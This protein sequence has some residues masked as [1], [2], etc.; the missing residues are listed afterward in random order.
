MVPFVGLVPLLAL[1]YASAADV[2][3]ISNGVASAAFSTTDGSLVSFIGADGVDRVVSTSKSVWQLEV[4]VPE[5]RG[6]VKIAAHSHCK[7][8]FL[9][10]IHI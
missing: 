2:V 1:A 10:L 3:N 8:S 9:S 4:V 7:V 6:S 5:Y